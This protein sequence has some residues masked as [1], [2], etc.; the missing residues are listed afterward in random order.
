VSRVGLVA[1]VLCA[2]CRQ[3]F[4]DVPRDDAPVVEV[5]AEADAAGDATM[6]VPDAAGCPAS[7]TPRANLT[8]LYRVALTP[9]MTWLQAEALCEADGTHLIVIND[10]TE[11]T[12]ARSLCPTT[13]EH[14]WLGGGDHLV[15]DTFGWINGQPFSFTRWGGTE[16]NNSGMI[17]DCMEIDSN[18]NWN[19]EKNVGLATYHTVCECDGL[20]AMPARCCDTDTNANCGTC[21]NTCGGTTTCTAQSCN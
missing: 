13:A 7:Y 3:H 11:N 19:D 15:E 16:P 12:F 18:G 21:G 10:A 5:D 6:L 17:E 1:L 9:S 4:D 14:V 20:P 2:A 8:S